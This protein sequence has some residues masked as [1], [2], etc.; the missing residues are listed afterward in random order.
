LNRTEKQ[1]GNHLLAR[2]IS[3]LKDSN[4]GHRKEVQLKAPQGNA[5]KGKAEKRNAAI[6]F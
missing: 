2:V 3:E 4:A 6:I 1:R 5:A